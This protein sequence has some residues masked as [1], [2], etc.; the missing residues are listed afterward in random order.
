MEAEMR[1]EDSSKDSG[2]SKPHYTG[3]KSDD[4][5]SFFLNLS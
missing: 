4:S 1:L 5:E 3:K 2:G